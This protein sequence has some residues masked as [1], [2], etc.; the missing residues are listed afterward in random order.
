MS[1]DLTA[2]PFLRSADTMVSSSILADVILGPG[3]L[4]G[5]GPCG[6]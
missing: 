3:D 5:G 6:Y 4:S 1:S 2:S